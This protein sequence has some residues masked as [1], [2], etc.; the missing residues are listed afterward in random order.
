MSTQ[1]DFRGVAIASSVKGDYQEAGRQ[2]VE[3]STV[4]AIIL[5]IFGKTKTHDYAEQIAAGDP[6]HHL[7]D[8]RGPE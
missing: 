5:F 1:D 3:G 2:T 6:L 8:G 7:P 4:Q